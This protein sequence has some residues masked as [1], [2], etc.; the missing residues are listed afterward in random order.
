M[1][2]L[3][4]FNWLSR[5]EFLKWVWIFVRSLLN[6]LIREQKHSSMYIIVIKVEMLKK[7]SQI[8][9]LATLNELNLYLLILST[10]YLSVSENSRYSKDKTSVL[11]NLY[12]QK[13]FTRSQYYFL[14]VWIKELKVSNE[15]K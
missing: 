6:F 9:T 14:S 12:N 7:G 11:A 4:T 2:V 13:K 1:M 15:I 8:D 5:G 3:F 10:K